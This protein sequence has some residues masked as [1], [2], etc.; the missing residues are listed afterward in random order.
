MGGDGNSG[1]K[2][3]DEAVVAVMQ[4]PHTINL[5]VNQS[6]T[7]QQKANFPSA[8]RGLKPTLIK[9]YQK[10]QYTNG[11]YYAHVFTNQ[12]SST[13]AATNTAAAITKC[14]GSSQ[15]VTP[16]PMN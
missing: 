7:K 14:D 11:N 12:V 1:V 9:P 16:V 5:K 10:A 2:S 13:S 15:T 6:M 3:N 4:G 8:R